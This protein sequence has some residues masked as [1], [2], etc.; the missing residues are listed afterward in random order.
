[1]NSEKNADSRSKAQKVLQK[2]EQ[3][4]RNE[5]S[6][7]YDEMN[8]FR[9]DL[10]M[11]AHYKGTLTPLFASFLLSTSVLTHSISSQFT[12]DRHPSSVP[13]AHPRIPQSTREICVSLAAFAQWVSRQSG[14]SRKTLRRNE[15]MSHMG[16]VID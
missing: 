16:R 2:S 12:A 7:A 5:F 11:H 14:W 9:C 4:G 10:C 1:M 8:P 6:I 15:Y 3:Q 13:T